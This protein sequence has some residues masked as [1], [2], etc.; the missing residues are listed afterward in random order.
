MPYTYNYPRVALCVDCIIIGT[1]LQGNHILLIERKN[2]PYAGTWAFPGGFHDPGETVEQAAARELEEETCLTNIH[3]SQ[4][5][6]FSDPK[7][8]PREQVI[9]VAFYGEISM[10][11]A[12]PVAADDAAKVQWFPLDQLPKLA[13]DHAKML[14]QYLN[15]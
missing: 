13:F 7:R 5:G 14:E 2:P 12:T 8:D 11:E 15:S 10:S 6:V 3:L 9:S 4:L 1:S